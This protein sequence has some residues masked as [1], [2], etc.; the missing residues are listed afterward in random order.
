MTAD[1]YA[2]D[3]S[4]SLLLMCEESKACEACLPMYRIA[5]LPYR[6]VHLWL[7]IADVFSYE[8]VQVLAKAADC[9]VGWGTS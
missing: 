6:E 4:Q 9:S 5:G 2:C 7:R 3:T 1:R 8:Y